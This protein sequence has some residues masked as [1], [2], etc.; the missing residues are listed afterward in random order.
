[1]LLGPTCR[2][3]LYRTGRPSLEG[4]KGPKRFSR[5]DPG[6]RWSYTKTTQGFQIDVY[7]DAML[8]QTTPR[9]TADDTGRVTVR[10]TAGPPADYPRPSP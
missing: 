5:D 8:N 4:Y 9:F 7:A 1:M 3:P 10:H 2:H 6:W